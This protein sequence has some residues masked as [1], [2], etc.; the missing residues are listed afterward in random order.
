[1]EFPLNQLQIDPSYISAVEDEFESSILAKYTAF[2]KGSAALVMA[3]KQEVDKYG[4][5]HNVPCDILQKYSLPLKSLLDISQN[6]QLD[7][8]RQVNK[9]TKDL[10]YIRDHGDE[11]SFIHT[12][13]LRKREKLYKKIEYFDDIEVL[14][15]A[16]EFCMEKNSHGFKIQNR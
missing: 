5:I 6:L 9:N 8:R 3:F 2:K 16:I 14:H 7:L 1:M 4:S 15:V 10:E 12:I 13:A 11:D